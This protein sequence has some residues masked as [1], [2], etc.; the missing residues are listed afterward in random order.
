MNILFLCRS[1][2]IG[3]GQWGLTRAFERRGIQVTYMDDD[4]PGD[5]DIFK[6]V[7]AC[8]VRPSLI[9]HPELD[10]CT[11]PRGLGKIEIPTACFQIDTYAYTRRRIRWSML[12]DH[13]IVFHPGYEEQFRKAGHRGV[14]TIYHAASRELFDKPEIQRIFDVGWVGR[15]SFNVHDS[16]RRVMTALAGRFRVNEWDKLYKFEEVADV[17]RSSRIVVNVARDDFP[18]DANMRAFEAMAAGCLLINRIPTELTE[19]G[20]QEGVHFVGYRHEGEIEHLVRRYLFQHEDR[21]RVARAGREKVL[22]EHT[23]DNRADT[24]L[25]KIGEHSSH[26]LAPARKWTDGRVRMHYVDYFSANRAFDCAYTQWRQL[27]MSDLPHAFTGG[28]FIARAWLSEL[29]RN[30]I[31]TR[32]TQP[33]KARPNRFRNVEQ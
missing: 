1:K 16:R 20:F 24:L 22:D 29:R 23:Y 33:N 12:F 21:N 14:V 26:F 9:L 17:Y 7:A 18:Q 30:L 4:A 31:S 6:L 13:P 11:L 3:W 5:E 28:K 25:R 15:S 32:G 2:D 27:A 19:I 8:P 10:F